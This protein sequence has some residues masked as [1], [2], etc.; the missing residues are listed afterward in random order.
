MRKNEL[1]DDDYIYFR[2]SLD[3]KNALMQETL[4]DVDR[5]TSSLV[6]KIVERARDQHRE[7][8]EKEVMSIAAESLELAERR[9]RG[10]ESELD[11]ALGDRDSAIESM[12]EARAEKAAF[13]EKQRGIAMSR[14]RA[15]ASA[16]RMVTMLLVGGLLA[17]GL[18]ISVPSDWMWQPKELAELPR[19]FVGISVAV[20]IS[21]SIVN[22]L[23]GSYLLRSAKKLEDWIFDHLQ[24]RYLKNSGLS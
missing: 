9:Q 13:L 22:L 1:S 6:H 18:W 10:L 11:A 2:Y 12:R 15:H 17:L 21:S 24:S 23:F 3:A 14:A 19:W 8:V 5:M 20:M 4:G 16:V 7:I